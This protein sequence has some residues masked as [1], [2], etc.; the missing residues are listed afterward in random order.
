MVC[1]AKKSPLRR[2]DR[3]QEPL[4]PP[5]GASTANRGSQPT[6]LPF[7]LPRNRPPP[8][9]PTTQQR[10]KRPVSFPTRKSL[11][12]QAWGLHA[13]ANRSPAVPKHGTLRLQPTLF[14]SPRG[15]DPSR[16]PLRNSIRETASN[17]RPKCSATI[18][19]RLLHPRD[20]LR[21]PGR[22]QQQHRQRCAVQSGILRRAFVA[23]AAVTD[24]ALES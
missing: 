17:N 11:Q 15:C 14:G 1:Q 13:S 9:P 10:E 6:N 20:S 23:Q 5:N 3:N 21:L 19:E 12:D 2:R 8:S 4:Q 7:Q 18:K 16:R 22:Q 24:A